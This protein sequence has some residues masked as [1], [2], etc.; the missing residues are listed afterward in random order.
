MESSQLIKILQEQAVLAD[1][2]ASSYLLD[3]NKKK[4][5]QR[6][7]YVKLKKYIDDFLTGKSATRWITL[8]GLRGSGKTTMLF[9]LYSQINASEYTK[10]FLSL[11]NTRLLLGVNLAEVLDAY[12]K[13]LGQPFEMLEKP[14][15]LF[16]DEVQYDNTW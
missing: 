16:L 13:I 8:I 1:F 6:N 2:R 11:D 7:I 12:E 3:Q 14:I 4:R 9:Q 10:L 15:I 5:P